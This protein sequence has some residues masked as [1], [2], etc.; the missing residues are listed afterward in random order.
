MK[1]QRS[2]TIVNTGYADFEFTSSASDVPQD[3]NSVLV[4]EAGFLV[5][6]PKGGLLLP[7]KSIQLQI[8]YL[9][10]IAGEFNETFTI[11]VRMANFFHIS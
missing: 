10:G 2:I 3:P 9:P 7:G 8:S 5:V 11:E 4:L 1:T 6:L